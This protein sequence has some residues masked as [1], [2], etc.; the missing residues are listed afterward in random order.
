MVELERRIKALQANPPVISSG[1]TSLAAT[2]A[3]NPDNPAYIQLQTQIEAADTDIRSLRAK[4]SSLK[5]K[6]GEYEQRLIETPQVEREY[7]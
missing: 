6:L 7:S 4:Q 1:H 5:D 3:D 2:A